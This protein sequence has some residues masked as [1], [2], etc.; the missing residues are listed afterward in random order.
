MKT[1][2]LS[3]LG[4][5][6]FLFSCQKEDS[7][8]V[9][10]KVQNY[11]RVFTFLKA[12]NP[13]FSEDL[14]GNISEQ[15]TTVRT[16]NGLNLNKL[17]ASFTST[18]RFKVF[19]GNKE[20]TSGQNNNNFS[21]P[22]VYRIIAPNGAANI[23]KVELNPVFSELNQALENL[24]QQYQVPG[25]SVAIVKNEKLVFAK[26]YG[27]AN[28]ETLQPVGT[29]SIFRIASIS[30][31]ITAVAILKLVQDGKLNLSDK[32]F[33][34]AGVLKN[35][36]GSVPMGSNLEAITVKNLLEHK[37]GWTNQ[38]TDPM[39]AN[40]NFSQQEVITDM[41]Q[42]RPLS[43]SPGSTYYYSNFGYCVLGRIIEKVTGKS[44]SSY[45]Q[46][47]ILQPLGIIDMRMANN[48][49]AQSALNEVT[50]YQPNDNAYAYH[51][52]RMDAHGGWLATA[53]DLMRL[54]FIST[55]IIKQLI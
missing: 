36:Y 42:N 17:I 23:Y 38:P 31:P 14:A 44:Y 13:E 9:S 27:Y 5:V 15:K 55:A 46:T 7:D 3:L 16:S 2:R 37:S 40:L 10:P 39:T 34:A 12:F 33:G 26:G 24:M 53:T 41:V 4:L 20:Q 8:L 29:E 18:D 32:V 21:V 49:Q 43:Y 30:K 1:G 48:S 22:V 11:L 35:D 25:L 28:K 50:Y 6:L 45:I 52:N 51:I 47:A 54:M 19:V